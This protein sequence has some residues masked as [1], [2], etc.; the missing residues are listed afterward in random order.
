MYF[1]ALTFPSVKIYRVRKCHEKNFKPPSNWKKFKLFNLKKF[2][3]TPAQTP[4]RQIRLCLNVCST[5]YGF[6][7]VKKVN[8]RMTKF[9]LMTF[10]RRTNVNIHW[11][12]PL[13]RLAE[14]RHGK[15]ADSS[16]KISLLCFSSSLHS[17]ITCVHVHFMCV[18]L[19]RRGMRRKEVTFFKINTSYVRSMDT[20][21]SIY[22]KKYTVWKNIC[23]A[24]KLRCFV[25]WE[26]KREEKIMQKCFF[27][28]CRWI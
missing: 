15:N 24:F 26:K 18:K 23:A 11:K 4:L 2:D 17:S 14:P 8:C 27:F 20:A 21:R 16:V 7:M 28:G 25:S 22:R 3:I 5:F 10:K 6:K 9:E 13:T 1:C 12:L 19:A